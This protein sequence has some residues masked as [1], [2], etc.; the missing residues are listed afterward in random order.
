MNQ[1]TV[2]FL[3]DQGEAHS[4]I[5]EFLKPFYTLIDEDLSFS[6]EGLKTKELYAQID[7]RLETT[8]FD[9]LLIQ[10]DRQLELFDSEKRRIRIDFDSDK[11]NY[12]R[13]VIA[14]DPFL[15]AIGQSRKRVLDV[16]AGLAIDS[17]FLSQHGHDVT[18][19]ER[20]PLLFSLLNHAKQTSENLKKRNIEFKFGDSSEFV[21]SLASKGKFDC[22]YFD[23]MFPD[24]AKSAL[25]KQEMVLFRQLVGN[26][27]DSE[28]VLETLLK[29]GSRVVVKRPAYAGPIGFKPTNAF[30][31]KL[32]RFDIYD[33]G[34]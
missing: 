15:R 11:L 34:L 25:P 14:K 6:F 18:A 9:F 1:K 21:K 7:M 23:P 10:H 19:V 3:H 13:K 16:S 26:D 12:A 33:N 28:A 31:S 2:Y 4:Q 27:L 30:E 17:V 8:P 29:F 20:N 22:I 24:K 32:I 5:T